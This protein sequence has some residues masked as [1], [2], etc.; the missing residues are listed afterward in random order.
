MGPLRRRRRTC[1]SPQRHRR[2][3]SRQPSPTAV[4]AA[5]RRHRRGG[6]ACARRSKRD[7]RGGAVHQRQDIRLA[8]RR[9]DRFRARRRSEPGAGD[10]T[11]RPRHEEGHPQLHRVG[12]TGCTAG[13]AGA[14][15][16]AAG[17]RR[18]GNAGGSC[19]GCCLSRRGPGRRELRA[20]DRDAQGHRRAH[21]PLARH[22]GAR[23]ERDRGRHVEG[24]GD[25]H[26][27]EEG[28]PAE[29]RRQPDVP[30]LR[31]ARG[32][33][34]AA[35]V[36]L[37]QRRDPRRPDRDAQ[38]RQPR[39]RRGAA[40]RQGPD[41]PGREERRDA[42]PAGDGEGRHRHRAARPRQEAAARRGAGRH[43]HDHQ[44]RRLRHL[45]RH[46]R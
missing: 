43:V 4:N 12:R 13:R 5:D 36:P 31:R 1:Q 34:D 41:R 10:R 16:G 15:R 22:L 38:L 3:P 6:E 46:A 7:D 29:L 14:A 33:R 19:S 28:V 21:A 35:R 32:G 11:R 45:P 27:A 23:H 44:P 25:P 2:Q 26:E 8:R 30:H 17:A 9:Q 37:G 39:L 20:D 40:G 42:Q 24:G 18:A